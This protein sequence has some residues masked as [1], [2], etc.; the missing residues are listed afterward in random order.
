M[1]SAFKTHLAQKSERAPRFEWASDQPRVWSIKI[2]STIHEIMTEPFHNQGQNKNIIKDEK[3]ALKT[4]GKCK[5]LASTKLAKQLLS[6]W[7][8]LVHCELQSF[9]HSREHY[10]C[11]QFCSNNS[12]CVIVAFYYSKYCSI[13]KRLNKDLYVLC[14]SIQF[15]LIKNTNKLCHFLLIYCL[16]VLYWKKIGPKMDFAMQLHPCSTIFQ[17]FQM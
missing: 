2:I 15:S 14:K 7:A 13:I 16:V 11:K 17:Q 3:A 10:D 12:K 5:R 8:N 1:Q 9:L 6:G 4:E